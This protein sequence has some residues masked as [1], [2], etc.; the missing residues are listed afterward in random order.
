VRLVIRKHIPLA[1]AF[2]HSSFSA[3]GTEGGVLVIRPLTGTVG[4]DSTLPVEVTFLPD[5]EDS[6]NF[7]VVCQL[8]K[9]QLQLNLNI[10][11]EAY[12]IHDQM[13]MA[14]EAQRSAVLAPDALN[15]I[16]IG[17]TN[18]NE[19]HTRRMVVTNSGRHNVHFSWMWLKRFPHSI[20]PGELTEREAERANGRQCG[21]WPFCDADLF[22]NCDELPVVFVC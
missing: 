15:C 11:G 1:F 22:W 21:K 6:Y 5:R 16:E 8:K 17:H 20:T 3:S 12:L 9:T 18:V 2:D 13:E 14:A 10:K 19:K 7:S 4:P